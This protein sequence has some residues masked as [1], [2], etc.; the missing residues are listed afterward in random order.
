M[1]LLN[2]L[3]SNMS[4]LILLKLLLRVTLG[5]LCGGEKGK[6]EARRGEEG[7]GEEMRG[8]TRKGGKRVEER[9]GK[10]RGGEERR[11]R[12]GERERE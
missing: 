3:G 8:H 4:D 6:A 9:R 11:E 7:R 12:K 10:E 2:V 1:I 5:A